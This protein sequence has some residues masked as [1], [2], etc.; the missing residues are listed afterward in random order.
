MTHFLRDILR[1]PRELQAAIDHFDGDAHPN[2]VEAAAV[3]LSARRTYLTAIGSSWNAALNARSL[4]HKAG[5]PVHLQDAAELLHWDALPEDTALIIISRTGRSAEIVNLLPK[6]RQARATVIGV[7]NSGDSPLVQQAQVPIVIPVELDHGISVNTYSTLSLAA[8]ILAS[9]VVG[10]FDSHLARTLTDAFAEC[11]KAL[12]GWQEQI[13]SAAWL[14]PHST[15]YFLARS[16][17]MGTCNEA[18]LLWEEA[19]KSP[20]TALG[21][22]AFRHGP[23]EVIAPDSRFGVW[24]DGLKMRQQDLAV[25]RDLTRLGAS[26][27]LVG[28]DLP[29]DAGDLIFQLPRVPPEWQ[30]LIDIMPAQLAAERLARLSGVDCDTFRLCSYVVEDEGGLLHGQEIHNENA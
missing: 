11:A 9:V 23:Q 28:Q 2:F 20:A 12:P 27:M 22:G 10:T 14:K 6:A 21:M 17:S 8:S 29:E 26:V 5:F 16:T 25:A 3:L 4:F 18:R 30:F 7:S 13:A 1:Q 24:I 15:Y 19:V